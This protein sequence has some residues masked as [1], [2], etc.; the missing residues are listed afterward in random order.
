MLGHD[1]K[2]S[3]AKFQGNRFRIDGEINEKHNLHVIVL[4]SLIIAHTCMMSDNKASYT[5]TRRR[6][7]ILPACHYLP[8]CFGSY[9][10]QVIAQDCL[11]MLLV[12]LLTIYPRNLE[13]NTYFSSWNQY[14][15]P[16]L[17]TEVNRKN[18]HNL[19][20]ALIF[21]YGGYTGLL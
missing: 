9:I 18:R 2:M 11:N 21:R 5:V 17:F 10:H 8:A 4:L 15:R 6:W 20:W 3:C 19:I 12:L 13:H 16:F 14:F 7:L 1:L